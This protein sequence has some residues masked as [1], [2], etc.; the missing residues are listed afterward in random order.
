[1]LRLLLT[2]CLLALASIA[3]AGGGVVL[4]NGKV[5]VQDTAYCLYETDDATYASYIFSTPGAEQLVFADACDL[6]VSDEL[7]IVHYYRISFPELGEELFIRYHPY[8]MESLAADLVKYKVFRDG[9]WNPVGA[10]ALIKAWRQ[11][12]DILAPE[13]IAS[14]SSIFSNAARN[15]PVQD[16]LLAG[17]RFQQQKIYRGDSVIG[18]YNADVQPV[19]NG[20]YQRGQAF[21]DL[22]DRNGNRLA[23]IT[24]PRRRA[25]AYMKIGD[26]E[27]SLQLLCPDKSDEKILRVATGVLLLRG[28]L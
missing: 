4:K 12:I 14:G 1:M 16:S 27:P 3:F 2:T 9:I 21:Y 13:K 11:K 26:E 10:E 6:S 5:W 22:Y 19:H 20:I 24:A 28:L 18:A 23:R 7:Y 17:I 8:R 25:V 15:T